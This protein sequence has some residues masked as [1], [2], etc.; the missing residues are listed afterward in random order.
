MG[1]VGVALGPHGGVE[2]M[3]VD[4]IGADPG[5]VVDGFAV[6]EA[7]VLGQ[8]ECRRIHHHG[9][10]LVQHG[11]DARRCPKRQGATVDLLGATHSHRRGHGAHQASVVE[12][13]DLFG[14]IIGDRYV[15]VTDSEG[16]FRIFL[17]E[18]TFAQADSV[19]FRLGGDGRMRRVVVLRTPVSRLV[20]NPI[21][22][23]G[24]R[25]R[26]R[27]RQPSFRGGPIC[28]R[29]VEVRNDD[30]SHA[31]GA[32]VLQRRLRRAGERHLRLVRRQ[33]AW[34]T[35]RPASRGHLL[36]PDWPPSG[37]RCAHSRAAPPDATQRGPGSTRRR[38]AYRRR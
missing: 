9:V 15:R 8:P 26:R 34:R 10:A 1:S 14:L 3:Q 16:H 19:D 31:V 13:A 6:A 23:T 5:R 24:H 33:S 4:A 11:V 12:D 30:R 35:P 2:L 32:A 37:C 18:K 7:G 28:D 25:W 20:V 29:L 27:H 17:T 21:P 22:R 38:S 36:F